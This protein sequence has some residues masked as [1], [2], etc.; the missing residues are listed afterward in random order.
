[1]KSL[2]D[3]RLLINGKVNGQD[4]PFLIDTGATIGL[5]DERLLKKLKLSKGKKANVSLIG[6]GGEINTSYMC[7][8]PVQFG[9][10]QVGQFI[11]SDISNIIES[12]YKQ[13]GFKIAGILSLPQMKFIG[14]Q[15]DTCH[16]SIEFE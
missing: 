10:K 13:T 5:I 2:S 9:D 11:F 1:M 6:A 12:I 16:N 7:N 8:T 14:M 15:V 3:K 4:W